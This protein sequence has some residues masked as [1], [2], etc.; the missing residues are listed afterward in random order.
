MNQGPATAG[1]VVDLDLVD[2]S[3]EFAVAFLWPE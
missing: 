2:L 1:V 3:L